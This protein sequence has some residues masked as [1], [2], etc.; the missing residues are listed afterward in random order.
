MA[1]AP[2]SGRSPI[3]QSSDGRTFVPET[4]LYTRTQ[5][6]V[7]RGGKLVPAMR[8]ADPAAKA[9]ADHMTQHYAAYAG[10]FPVYRKLW[11]FAKLT[12]VAKAVL[13]PT[14]KD[15]KQEQ[16]RPRPPLDLAWLSRDYRPRPAKTVETTPALVARRELTDAGGRATGS[17]KLAGGVR[18]EPRNSY[19]TGGRLTDA[20]A[21][22]A[23]DARARQPR[24][25]NWTLEVEGRTYE[26]AGSAMAPRDGVR[27]WQTDIEIGDVQITRDYPMPKATPAFGGG[28]ALRMPCLTVDERVVHLASGEVC[29][30]AVYIREGT[31]GALTLGQPCRLSMPGQPATSGYAS[32]DGNA[33]IFC[34]TNV[35]RCIEGKV[36][37]VS[38]GRGPYTM[39]LSPGARLIDFGPKAPHAVR[40]LR[41]AGTCVNYTCEGGRLVKLSDERGRFVTLTYDQQ[42]LVVNARASDGRQVD[43]RREGDRLLAVVNSDGRG[44]SYAWS[45]TTG[46]PRAVQYEAVAGAPVAQ[47]DIIELDIEPL[48]PD[49]EPPL[50]KPFVRVTHAKP[51]SNY[52]YDIRVGGRRVRSDGKLRRHFTAVLSNDDPEGEHADALR[53]LFIL[54]ATAE[55]FERIVLQAPVGIREPLAS[56]LR[57]AAPDLPIA[58]ASS[59]ELAQK[60]L[61]ARPPVAGPPRVVVSKAGLEGNIPDRL[62]KLAGEPSAASDAATVI[63]AG[64]NCEEFIAKIEQLGKA[65]EL[66]GKR[67]VL[68]ACGTRETPGMVAHTLRRHGAA[69]VVYFPELIDPR[70]LPEIVEHVQES[71]RRQGE[72]GEPFLLRKLHLLLEWLKENMPGVPEPVEQIGAKPRHRRRAVS[73]HADSA[74]Q[75][76]ARAAA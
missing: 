14:E 64:D 13:P 10:G 21:K 4:R 49:A 16:A 23:L 56:A 52:D 38:T 3:Y 36:K 65:G 63:I 47:T 15:S 8:R 35:W 2:S 71:L 74:R 69:S 37:W 33:R 45:P 62:E 41:T 6:M 68:A 25:R 59:L 22:A 19:K 34:Y 11:A 18:L 43:Y 48:A 51:G 32:R 72:Q 66:R 70:R 9:F 55:G 76:Q 30:Q 58:M 67:V 46:E 61:A 28:F 29:P 53:K 75:A 1:K 24:R 54:P 17:L 26:M 60:N 57:K 50:P 20:L 7:P 40:S 42:G 39:R 12:S 31:G 73:A 5:Y 44:V 27:L